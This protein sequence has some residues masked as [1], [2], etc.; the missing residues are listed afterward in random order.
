M[1][2]IGHA[3]RKEFLIGPTWHWPL[4]YKLHVKSLHDHKHS[5]S[6]VWA[7][8]NQSEKN[9]APDK[10]FIY[11]TVITLSFNW[12]TWFK[13]TALPLLNYIA[14]CV[15]VWAW[16]GRGERKYSLDKWSWTDD[17]RSD[18][19][20]V[21][22]YRDPNSQEKTN[23]WLCNNNC[24]KLIIKSRIFDYLCRKYLTAKKVQFLP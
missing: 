2:Q 3:L 19:Y 9:Y 23:K 24:N 21:P 1:I 4:T 14:Q 15:E 8:L 18:H 12:E 16:L 22:A 11:N 20:K 6:E 7:R 17:G 5:M 13:I 10:D